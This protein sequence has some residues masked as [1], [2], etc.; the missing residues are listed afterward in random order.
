M[1]SVT[2][3]KQKKFIIQRRSAFIYVKPKNAP[4]RAF[5]KIMLLKVTPRTYLP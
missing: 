4:K 3:V 1:S 5:K 2:V